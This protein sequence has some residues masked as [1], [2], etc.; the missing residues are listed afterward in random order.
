MDRL[1]A[2]P[3][4]W[5][6]KGRKYR[7]FNLEFPVRIKIESG[8]HGSEFEAISKNVSVGGLLVRSA[9]LIPEHSLVTFILSVHGEDAVRP[10][11]LLG[12]GEIVRVENEPATDLFML[13]VE[14][15]S[16]VLQ[17]EEYLPA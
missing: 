6:W 11:H 5:N 8:A 12:E 13:A 9:E 10:I 14:C 15:K 3:Q 1:E 4:L 17:L 7:R 16:P 2:V